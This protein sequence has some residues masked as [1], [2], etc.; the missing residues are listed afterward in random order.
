MAGTRVVVDVQ[1]AVTMGTDVHA[2]SD[3]MR[4]RIT[5]E[6]A[7]QLELKVDEVNVTIADVR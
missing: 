7:R 1:A 3:E 6:I 4:K 5:A 2:L